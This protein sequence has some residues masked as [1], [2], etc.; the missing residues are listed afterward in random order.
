MG[1]FFGLLFGRFS[2]PVGYRENE[3]LLIALKK[4]S[5]NYSVILSTAE[6]RKTI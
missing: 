3:S 5:V 6:A 2:L 4:N 1:F